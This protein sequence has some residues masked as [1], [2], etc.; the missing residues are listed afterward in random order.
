MHDNQSIIVLILSSKKVIVQ[1]F[2]K[3]PFPS[4][5][6]LMVRKK[7]DFMIRITNIYIFNMYINTLLQKIIYEKYFVALL[8]IFIDFS[9]IPMLTLHFLR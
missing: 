8:E 9:S 6:H 1:I 4:V 2:D 3:I 5:N 7:N